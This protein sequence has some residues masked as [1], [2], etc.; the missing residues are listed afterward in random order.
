MEITEDL[1]FLA[2]IHNFSHRW[3]S[4]HTT[5]HDLSQSVTK[6]NHPLPGRRGIAG[7]RGRVVQQ[8]WAAKSKWQQNKCFKSKSF[9]LCP[10]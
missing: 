2:Y 5:S 9:I 3:L 1:S 4:G 8:P 6:M 10:K 7:G